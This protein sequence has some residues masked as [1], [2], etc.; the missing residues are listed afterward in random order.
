MRLLRGLSTLAVA[1]LLMGTAAR[2]W[3]QPTQ[4]PTPTA[5]CAPAPPSRLIL[6]ERARVSTA[7]PRPLNLR[8]GAGT[9]HP[10][11]AQIPASGVFY[12]L[13]GPTCGQNYAWYRVEFEGLAGWI[14]EGDDKAYFVELYPPG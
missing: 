3:M 10:V 11:I 2:S 1:A 6:R 7:D 9:S 12:V 8:D 4:P 14:A 13:E 5:A